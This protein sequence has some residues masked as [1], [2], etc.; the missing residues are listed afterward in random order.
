MDDAPLEERRAHAVQTRR[1]RRRPAGGGRRGARRRGRR[2]GAAGGG[3]RSAR[4]RRTARC[5][6]DVRRAHVRRVGVV[7]SRVGRRRWWRSGR[8]LRVSAPGRSPP[9]GCP[10][11]RRVH[12]ALRVA[13]ARS[14]C[15]PVAPRETWTAGEALT[16]L[17]RSRLTISGPITAAALARNCWASPTRRSTRRCWRSNR[18][19][20]CCA[21]ASR[22]RAA[23][24]SGAT[25][26]CSRASTATRCRGCAPR[27]SR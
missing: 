24:P 6:D 26:R 22:R 18:K 9:S 1:G 4:R 13:E 16:E 8:A 14:S 19:A 23:R 2:Q 25:A 15:P 7:R 27:S 3:A 10:N 11:G 20:S 12:P 5:A 17:V 21:A